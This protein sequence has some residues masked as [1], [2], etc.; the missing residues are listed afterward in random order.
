MDYND[1][2]DGHEDF[3][4][5]DY[6]YGITWI[7]SEQS[8]RDELLTHIFPPLTWRIISTLSR[9]MLKLY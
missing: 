7:E 1:D 5:D 6:D 2:N 3:D 8:V 9:A 4:D